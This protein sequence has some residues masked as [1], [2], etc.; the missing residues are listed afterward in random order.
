MLPKIILYLLIFDY[1]LIFINNTRLTFWGTKLSRLMCLNKKCQTDN[2]KTYTHNSNT[3]QIVIRF[4]K[5]VIDSS[6]VKYFFAIQCCCLLFVL[7]YRS[8]EYSVIATL[9]AAS[10][11]RFI[12]FNL[13][14]HFGNFYNR[15]T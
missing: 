10:V 2:S 6:P 15:C 8:C 14:T 9:L 5:R 3:I 12:I 11:H 4:S 7:L 13:F 1:V